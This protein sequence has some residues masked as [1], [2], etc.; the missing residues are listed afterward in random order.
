MARKIIG[1][2]DDNS[3]F[4]GCPIFNIDIIDILLIPI[5]AIPGQYI[6]IELNLSQ[7]I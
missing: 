1:Q 4:K 3:T 5:T 7:Q 2:P 6:H